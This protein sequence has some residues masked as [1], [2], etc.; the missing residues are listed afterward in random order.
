LSGATDFAVIVWELETEFLL[1]ELIPNNFVVQKAAP[2]FTINFCTLAKN[3]LF[4]MMIGTVNAAPYQIWIKS[5]SS[6]G[7]L[8]LA[9]R[10]QKLFT[11]MNFWCGQRWNNQSSDFGL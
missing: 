8:T 7:V 9:K 4:Y 2:D 1:T 5:I 10:N 3:Q 11:L 6:L